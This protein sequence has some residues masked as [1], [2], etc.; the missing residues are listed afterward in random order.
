MRSR[1]L[2]AAVGLVA[3]LALVLAPAALGA[4]P[5][6]LR[7]ALSSWAAAHPETSALVWRL[8]ESGPVPILQW[9]PEVA[10]T[11]ASTMKLVTAAGA[12]LAL[13]PQFRFTTRLYAGVNSVQ[14][15]DVLTGPVYLVGGGDPMLSTRAFAQA[16]LA[17][18]GG[19]L[20]GLVAPLRRRG[21]REVRGPIVAD[22]GLF[23][24]RRLGPQWKDSY[25][26]ECPPLSALAVN[27]NLTDGGGLVGDPPTAAA[28]RLRAAMRSMGVRQS[29]PLR[30]GDAPD[31]GR[32]LATV[33][34]PTVAEIVGVMNPASDNFLAEMLRKDVGAYAGGAG[35]TEAGSAHTASVLRERGIMGRNDRLV[36]GS[37]LSRA[38]SLSAATLVRLLAA[39]VQDPVWGEPLIRSMARGG[40]GTL[41]RRFLAP[42]VSRRV[43]GKTGYI[44]GVSS[45]AGVVTSRSGT[46][47]AFAFLMN[48]PDIGGAQATQNAVVELLAR[49]AGDR[50]N[51]IP[52]S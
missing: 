15:G 24:S 46:R 9:R 49:G 11:P 1:I 31:T 20:G 47:Y 4:T 50:A 8:D 39:A 42:D 5:R 14:R 28:Q 48:D 27:R 33:E 30:P 38:N 6:E 35:T 16:A 37:G 41:R 43:R 34:S 19:N 51:P 25:R 12:L 36:D 10:R 22:E 2:R 7:A 52:P 40:E 29:G 13:G 23:D 3:V 21:I 17:G 18:R 32:P 45:L 44:D 26:F